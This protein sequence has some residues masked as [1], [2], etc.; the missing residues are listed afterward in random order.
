LIKISWKNSPEKFEL[1]L[2]LPE[3]KGP[4]VKVPKKSGLCK[5]WLNQKSIYDAGKPFEHPEGKFLGESE[6]Y[7][8]ILLFQGGT[9]KLKL[10]KVSGGRK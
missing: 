3:G 6:R 10:E 5:I 2:N 9:Y 4:M 1:E 7:Y 8:K